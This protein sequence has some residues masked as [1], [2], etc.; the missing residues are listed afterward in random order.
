MSSEKK[1][2]IL[3][4]QNGSDFGKNMHKKKLEKKYQNID[5][6]SPKGAKL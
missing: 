6:D 3:H 5:S 1:H 2:R 4:I